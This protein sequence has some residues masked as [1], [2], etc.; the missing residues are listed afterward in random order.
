MGAGPGRV[1]MPYAE[2]P[3][4][5]KGATVTLSDLISYVPVTL[6]AVTDS[7][8]LGIDKFV[9]RSIFWSGGV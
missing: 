2:Q 6:S 7:S 1:E 4:H 5:R 3:E 8:R 9:H